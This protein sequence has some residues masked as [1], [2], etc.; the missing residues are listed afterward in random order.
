LADRNT[1]R[2][3]SGLFERTVTTDVICNLAGDPEYTEWLAKN[4]FE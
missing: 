1:H 2:T 3:F 4:V